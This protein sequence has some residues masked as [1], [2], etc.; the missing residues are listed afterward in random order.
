MKTK[1]KT[2]KAKEKQP[3]TEAT[4]EFWDSLFDK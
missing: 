2:Q 3:T 1:P 4:P